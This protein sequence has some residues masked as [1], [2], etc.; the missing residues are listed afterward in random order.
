M[1]MVLI[2]KDV[3]RGEDGRQ[4]G[5]TERETL[6]TSIMSDDI[7]RFAKR[8]AARIRE[9]RKQAPFPAGHSSSKLVP[10]VQIIEPYPQSRQSVPSR[11]PPRVKSSTST[12]KSSTSMRA[13][14]VSSGVGVKRSS[15]S[16][17][18][19]TS[20]ATKLSSQL[21]HIRH[22]IEG[23]A[24]RLAEDVPSDLE[25]VDTEFDD[26]SNRWF[27]REFYA[28]KHECNLIK[29]MRDVGRQ[30]VGV[31]KLHR[32]ALRLVQVA[33]SRPI[34]RVLNPHIY[35][36]L[37]DLVRD[38][39]DL[40]D[41]LEL[42]LWDPEPILDALER[43]VY[44][45]P[46][47]SHSRRASIA[48]SDIASVIPPQN[49][50]SVSRK[51]SKSVKNERK[52]STLA[53]PSNIYSPQ[54]RSSTKSI[55]SRRSSATSNKSSKRTKSVSSA[56]R[57]T[58]SILKKQT[59]KMEPNSQPE[60]GTIVGRLVDIDSFECPMGEEGAENGPMGAGHRAT[61]AAPIHDGGQNNTTDDKPDAIP[62]KT[63]P[64]QAPETKAANV[65]EFT[66]LGKMSRGELERV[67][68]QLDRIEREENEVRRRLSHI[69]NDHDFNP[70]K[71]R[72]S[73]NAKS[74]GVSCEQISNELFDLKLLQDALSKTE[75]PLHRR[76]EPRTGAEDS[77][78]LNAA[79]TLTNQI[80]EEML[81]SLIDD[82]VG[83]TENNLG[84]FVNDI[85]ESELSGCAHLNPIS[86]L[87]SSINSTFDESTLNNSNILAN[88]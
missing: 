40:S 74:R 47:R 7:L 32:T 13:K 70:C 50:R 71:A 61:A 12:A 88:S 39:V 23:M 30:R 1:G 57:K 14:S 81:H 75:D 22:E 6:N 17:R 65:R 69:T 35:G 84:S 82:V 28:V 86:I 25:D 48:P 80:A 43:A 51:P 49:R 27:A 11:F 3:S 83:E 78:K 15:L 18:S 4:N 68:S 73:V 52:N 37:G 10:P 60:V 59:S 53:R 8:E 67:M 46:R 33:A 45:P 41:A 56:P 54:K 77:P 76:T 44:F 9:M 42:P 36:Q 38:L 26:E 5:T 85:Y 24:E 55:P 34:L 29:K 66:G 16:V 64:I 63:M 87:S 58:K 62:G 21:L 19:E 2:E 31:V 79:A 72:K 20:V